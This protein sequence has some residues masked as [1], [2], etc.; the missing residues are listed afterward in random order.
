MADRGEVLRIELG[1]ERISTPQ[2]R[3][4]CAQ[5]R[6]ENL[7]TFTDC[8]EPLAHVIGAAI[9]SPQ[10]A[11]HSFAFE[12]CCRP[13]L[14]CLRSICGDVGTV[15]AFWQAHLHCA[16]GKPL[17]LRPQK[18]EPFQPS[19]AL[20]F[21]LSACYS[22]S[23]LASSRAQYVTITSAPARFRAVMISSTAA[24]SSRI[25]FSTAPLTIAY[26]PLT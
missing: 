18:C 26:S 4:M 16:G 17:R 9:V 23:H 19:M 7:A 1:K 3:I 5:A 21:T 10:I 12:D 22:L 15:R 6:F 25:P 2:A 24:R 11:K 13:D 14:F 20:V 8:V